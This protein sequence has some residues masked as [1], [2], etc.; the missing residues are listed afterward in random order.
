MEETYLLLTNHKEFTLLLLL[1]KAKT[2]DREY[3]KGFQSLPSETLVLSIAP[4]DD[5]GTI[6]FYRFLRGHRS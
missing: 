3:K 5:P 2:E 4:A 6:L 1:A